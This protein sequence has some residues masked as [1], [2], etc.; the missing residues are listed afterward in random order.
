[1][2]LRVA[3][4]VLLCGLTGAEAAVTN[5]VDNFNDTDAREHNWMYWGV[6]TGGGPTQDYAAVWMANGGVG[7]SSRLTL[8]LQDAREVYSSYWPQYLVDDYRDADQELDFRNHSVSAI[9]NS[10]NVVDVF[11]GGTLHFFIG[12][13]QDSEHYSFYYHDTA[14]TVNVPQG[15]WSQ[16]TTIDIGTGDEDWTLLAGSNPVTATNLFDNPQQYGFVI[17]GAGSQPTFNLSMDDFSAIQTIPEPGV[18]ALL[19]AGLTVLYLYRRRR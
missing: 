1:M 9:F 10:H 7:N 19:G 17:V 13:W 6:P 11:N 2:N 16:F 15:D 12:E 3:I 8:D 4:A 5:Y 18:L 14:F